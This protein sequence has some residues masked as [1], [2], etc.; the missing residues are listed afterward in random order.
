MDVTKPVFVIGNAP[1]NQTICIA[2]GATAVSVTN[3]RLNNEDVAM[4]IA[5]PYLESG[6]FLHD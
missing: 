6:N 3:I 2:N 5:Q 1:V 4:I